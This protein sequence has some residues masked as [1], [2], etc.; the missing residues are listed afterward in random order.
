MISNFASKMRLSSGGKKMRTLGIVVGLVALACAGSFAATA[1][2]DIYG[3]WQSIAVPIVPLDPVPSHV[4]AP[5]DWDN[6]NATLSRWDPLAPGFVTYSYNYGDGVDPVFGGMLLGD[7][8]MVYPDYFTGAITVTGLESG[9]P[10]T[11]GGA[12]TDMWISLP[13]IGWAMIGNP[14]AQDF[15]I[16]QDLGTPMSFTDGTTVKGWPDAVAAGWVAEIA[17]RYD[18][19][20][21]RW[22]TAGINYNEEWGWKKSAGYILDVKQDNLAMIITAPV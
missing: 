21:Q 18:A 12:K 2:I 5:L 20:L 9:V 13:K 1:T 11:T 17:L 8:Y 6:S 22:V 15:D 19:V 10:A 4:L 14:Y 3:G 7:G 16:D